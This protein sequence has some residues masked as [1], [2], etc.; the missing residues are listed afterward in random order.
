M[1]LN[2][3][4]VESQLSPTFKWISEVGRLQSLGHL[5][6]SSWEDVVGDSALAL[7]LWT[8]ETQLT[9]SPFVLPH[10]RTKY[11]WCNTPTMSTHS[12][13]S[14]RTVM[15]TSPREIHLRTYQLT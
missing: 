12:H 8:S 6:A 3:A 7:K 15:N 13:L 14:S 10:S 2:Q 9:M 1:G 11:R 5:M 4:S